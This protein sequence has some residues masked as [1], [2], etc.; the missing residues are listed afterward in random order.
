MNYKHHLLFGKRNFN[1]VLIGIGLMLL[2]FILMIG[3]GDT[4]DPVNIY[5]EDTLYGFQRTILAPML[6]LIGL[7][8]QVVAIFTKNEKAVD[9]TPDT[10]SFKYGNK[11]RG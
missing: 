7:G 9:M 3:G 5:P 11:K 10:P 6:V 1:I 2:G 8:V 4:P